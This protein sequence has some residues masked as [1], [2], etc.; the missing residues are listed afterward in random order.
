[1]KLNEIKNGGRGLLRV[2]YSWRPRIQHTR[3][4]Y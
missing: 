4:T 1:M 2:G 3:D